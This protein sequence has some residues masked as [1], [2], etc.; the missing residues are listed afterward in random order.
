MLT[1]LL[2]VSQF[3]YYNKV[4]RFY[5][6]LLTNHGSGY[7]TGDKRTHLELL[8]QGGPPVLAQCFLQ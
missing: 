6:Q 3:L 7:K 4:S 8:K 2:I 1:H 5:T